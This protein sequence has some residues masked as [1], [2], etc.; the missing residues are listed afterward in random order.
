MAAGV[1]DHVW[2]LEEI[3]ALLDWVLGQ[4]ESARRRLTGVAT[5][6]EYRAV[7]AFASV[8]DHGTPQGVALALAEQWLSKLNKLGAEGW[9]LV[10]EIHVGARE[11]AEMH[12]SARSGTMKRPR[13]G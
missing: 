1:A 8:R 6:W 4:F 2:T 13:Q 11:H 9:E 3:A 5:T 12:W 10:S 7:S